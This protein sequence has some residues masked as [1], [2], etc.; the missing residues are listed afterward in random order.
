L[1]PEADLLHL[2]LYLFILCPQKRNK[3]K[4]NEYLTRVQNIMTYVRRFQLPET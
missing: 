4:H 3:Y 2:Q 1:S